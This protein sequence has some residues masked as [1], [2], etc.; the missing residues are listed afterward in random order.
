MINDAKDDRAV[1]LLGQRGIGKTAM[2]SHTIQA[3]IDEGKPANQISLISFA[4][5]IFKGLDLATV[6]KLNLKALDVKSA[7]NQV[8]IFEEIQYCSDWETELEKIAKKYPKAL[9]IGSSSI[10]IESKGKRKSRSKLFHS[11]VL[12]ILSFYEFIEIRNQQNPIYFDDDEFSK[13][14]IEVFNQHLM[15]YI[16]YGN[17]SSVVLSNKINNEQIRSE[18]SRYLHQILLRDL[19]NLYGINKLYK[20]NS[21]TSFLA[22]NSGI[23]TNV[24]EL[25]HSTGFSKDAVIKYLNYLEH[26]FLIKRI[27]RFNDR[28]TNDRDDLYFRVYI[29]NVSM[30]TALFTPLTIDDI[31]TEYMVETAIL[32]QWQH[33]EKDMFY[34]CKHD[35]VFIDLIKVDENK[36]P[37]W[38][39]D[40]RWQHPHGLEHNELDIVGYFCEKHGLLS[41]MITTKETRDIIPSSNVIHS[42]EPASLYCYSIG[43]QIV[44]NKMID[45]NN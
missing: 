40:V 25:V 3:L 29:T 12:P 10:G 42:Y 11:F 31:R 43:K 19:P 41:S 22:Y 9:F 26:I 14:Q 6:V 18:G 4:I 2:L 17:Y 20:L 16:N 36:N 1:I 24:E 8:F 45:K 15:N 35:H 44:E 37:V 30:R 33:V 7:D 21:F 34:Y 23:E 39:T 13:E 27:Y 38:I 32:A 5:P 28:H